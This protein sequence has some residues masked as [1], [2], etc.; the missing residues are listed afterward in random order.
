MEIIGFEKELFGLS[1][2]RINKL[3]Y[4]EVGLNDL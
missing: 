1:N 2:L 4:V 3:V